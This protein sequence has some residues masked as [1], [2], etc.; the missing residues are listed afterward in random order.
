MNIVRSSKCTT[1]WLTAEKRSTLRRVLEEYGRVQET[2][3][4]RR[5]SLQTHRYSPKVL[6]IQ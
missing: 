5:N 4:K 1:K 6:I 3:K 2:L